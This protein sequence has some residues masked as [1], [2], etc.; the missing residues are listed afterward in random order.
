MQT[1]C[2]RDFH[3]NFP[4]ED[5]KELGMTCDLPDRAKPRERGVETKSEEGSGIMVR[6][7]QRRECEA[8]KRSGA[9]EH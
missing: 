1:Q 4:R 9:D 2:R 6:A 3:S 7:A 5:E 8:S